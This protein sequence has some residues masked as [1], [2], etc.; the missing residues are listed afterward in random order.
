MSTYTTLNNVAAPV[1]SLIGA[2]LAIPFNS[3]VIFTLLSLAL[4]VCGASLLLIKPFREFD[5]EKAALLH[6]HVPNSKS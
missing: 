1:G 3:N 4:F 2:T 5:L 6:N